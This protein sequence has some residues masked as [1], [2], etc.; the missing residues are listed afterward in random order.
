MR[1]LAAAV[2]VAAVQAIAGPRAPFEADVFNCVVPADAAESAVFSPL[3]FEIDCAV[4]GRCSEPLARAKFADAMGVLNGFEGLFGSMLEQ[5]AAGL[6]TNHFSFLSARAF[7]LHDLSSAKP[8]ARQVLQNVYGAETCAA[9]PKAGPESW[10][11]ARLDG[12]MEDFELPAET[13]S[14]N[15]YGYLDLV[16]ARWSWDEPFPSSDSRGMAFAALDGSRKSV[17]AI[18]DIRRADVMAGRGFSALRLRMAGD[19]WFYALL[20][21]E[22]VPLAELR[23]EFS[24]ARIVDGL[25]RAMESIVDPAVSHEPVAVAIPAMDI[26]SSFDLDRAFSRLKLPMKGLDA[27]G[28]NLSCRYMRQRMRFR[29]DECGLAERVAE[30]P[31][32]TKIKATDGTRTFA[33]NRP[34]LFF[35]YHAPTDTI[36]VAG[37]FTGN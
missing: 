5:Y 22:G 4:F 15:V 25:L 21:A 20:P 24:A 17:R 34:F 2:A 27:L 14:G 16:S 23:R 8:D 32:A 9:F 12:E 19:S 7:C 29:L 1:F 35:I 31:A 37:Q 26:S 13:I 3:S 33:L 28:S 36:P 30:K 18:C 6:V 10:F 11:R